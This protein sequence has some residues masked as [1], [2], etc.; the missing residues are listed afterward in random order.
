MK[1]L[2]VDSSASAA[3]AAVIEDGKILG[4]MY[5]NTGLTHSRT[6]MPAVEAVLECSDTLLADVDVLA[7]TNG[8][9]SFTGVRIGVAAVKGMADAAGKKCVGVSTLL[10]MAYNLLSCGCVICAAMDARCSQ[11]YTALFESDGKNIA[12][13]TDD[14]AISVDDLGEELKKLKKKIIFVGDGAVLCYNKL[15]DVVKDIFIA[16]ENVRLQR[17]SGAATAVYL[18]GLYEKAVLPEELTVSYLRPSQA[19]RELNKKKNK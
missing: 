3:S 12:R 1:I 9:G 4:E 17:A 11:V 6:L 15:K 5:L 7:V 8:P 18:T 16:D 14:R 10:S 19:E 13:L 2:S